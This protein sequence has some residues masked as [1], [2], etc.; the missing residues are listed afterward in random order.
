MTPITLHA[1]TV[2]VQGRG[3]L[4]IGPSGS[5][6]SS[7]ALQLIALGAS[8]LADDRT[9][10]HHDGTRLLAR[11]P[12]ALHGMI[13]ARG[14]GIPHLPFVT[15]APV[16]LVADLAQ[17][18]TERLPPHRSIDI[19]ATPIELVLGAQS[20]HFAAALLCYLRFGRLA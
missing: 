10:L 11:C 15:E 4:I 13:E 6:K 1:T 18:E 2:A 16:C 14:V 5:G 8:L 3:L 19:L 12:D 7:L 9:D 17:T 20:P